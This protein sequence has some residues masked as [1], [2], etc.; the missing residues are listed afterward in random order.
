MRLNG[1]AMRALREAHGES[2]SGCARALKI[3]QAQWSNWERGVR[4][5]T[6]VRVLAIAHLLGV[7]YRAILA[8]PSEEEV[9]EVEQLVAA[10]RA[11]A[12]VPVS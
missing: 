9:A 8:D 7:D 1:F 3:S 2:G 11:T 6:P 4:E 12:A 10:V 5:A